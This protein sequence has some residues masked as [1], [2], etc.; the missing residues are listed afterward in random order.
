M[1]E[2]LKERYTVS[3]LCQTL[4]CARSS[5]YYQDQPDQ[6][7]DPL[8]AAMEQILVRWPFYGY[9]RVQAQLERQGWSVGERRVRRL[10]KQLGH[11]RNVG[12]VRVRTTDSQHN[13]PRFPNRLKGVTLIRPDQAWMADITFIRLGRRFIFL[14]VILDGYSRAVRGW[15]ISR[16]L[17]AEGLTIPAL[18]MALQ[19]GLPTIFHSDQGSQYAAAAHLQPLLDLGVIISMTDAGQPTQ[20]GLVERFM[21]TLKEEHVDYTEYT[22]FTDAVG[23]LRQWLEVEYMTERIHSALGYATPAE[24]EVAARAAYSPSLISR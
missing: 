24:F 16:R 5:Y 2:Q 9:R 3:F 20:N 22:D 14:A 15:A 12:P 7:D 1:I 18:H 6:A 19:H 13:G 10:L 11:S 21:R 17:N 8:L 23:Q 4:D